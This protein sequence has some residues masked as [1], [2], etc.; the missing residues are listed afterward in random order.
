MIAVLI[1]DDHV[2]VRETWSFILKTY[3]QIGTVYEC[4]SGIDAISMVKEC[5]PDVVLMDINM[6]PISG[7]EAT[8]RI[9][10]LF[11]DTRIIGISTYSDLSY[12]RKIFLAGASGYVTKNSPVGEMMDAISAVMKNK[13]YL[14]SELSHIPV[15]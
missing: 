13:T 15:F 1:V 4:A 3:P 5:K 2:L 8:E 11:P 9:M 10:E 12:V 6:E 7:I 14:C